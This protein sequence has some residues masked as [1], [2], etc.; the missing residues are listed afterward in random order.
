MKIPEKIKIGGHWITVEKV[1]DKELES[2]LGSFNN[3]YQ[4]IRINENDTAENLQAETFL[5][6]IFEAIK[7]KFEIKIKHQDLTIL[8]ELLF[9]VIIDNKLDFKTIKTKGEE[10]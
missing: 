8:S 9:Q 10:K 7:K 1:G 3:W 5:H 2:D 6:E 4:Y